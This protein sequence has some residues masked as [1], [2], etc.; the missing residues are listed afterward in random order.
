MKTLLSIDGGGVRGM[1][2]A[3]I[4][5]FLEEKLQE[6]DGPDVRIADYFDIIA[7]TSTGGLVTAMLTAPNEKNHPI[8]TAKDIT[9]FY[10][11]KCPY[12]F[13]PPKKGI[14]GWLRTQYRVLM[15]PKYSGDFLH[16][17]IKKLCRDI[18]LN[19]TL[20]DIVIPAYDINLQQPII[21]SSLEARKD[22]SKDA[23]LSDV[24]IGTSAAPMYLP[25][26]CFTT[27]DSQ[28]KPRSFHLIDG[29]VA[30]ND[31]TSLAIN[32]LMNEGLT[33]KTNPPQN[34]WS[35]CLVLS[36]GTGQKIAGYKA[37]DTAKW[38]L[39]GWLNKNGKAP[40]IDIL[41][42]SSTDMVDIHKSFLLKAFNMH[43]Y[44]RIQE[45]ELGDDRS[46]FDLSTEENL[47][48]LKMIGTAL[49]DK[50]VSTLNIET[51]DY[52]EL[53]G[54]NT[55]TNREALTRFAKLLSDERK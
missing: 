15:G 55:E 38:G 39:F 16:S 52:E 19:E 7:G 25:S 45:P 22:K 9:R 32:H 40:L 44:L 51:G 13:P 18:R 17:I 53:R 35:K 2:P 20:T 43:T 14:W 5:E 24:C 27:Q 3:T 23:F 49:L 21:F 42:Q 47:N 11:E 36:L 46:S 31:P 26:H 12:I 29:G 41:M 54:E 1:I 48:G 34:E 37:T 30:A 8:F 10:L 33:C 6:L 28:G 50:P 4:L